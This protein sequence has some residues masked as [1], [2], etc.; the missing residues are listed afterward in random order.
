MK[1]FF[2]L[3][4]FSFALPGFS[5]NDTVIFSQLGHYY[6]SPA[7]SY[8]S[9]YTPLIDRLNRPYVYAASKEAGLVTFDISNTLNPFPAHTETVAMLNNLKPTG[10]VQDSIYLLVSLGDFEGS[11][12]SAGL[13]I[14]DISTPTSPVLLDLWDSTYFNKGTA[15]VIFQGNYA[16]LA[17]MDSGVVILDISNKTDI[18]YVSKIRPDPT[19]FA[20]AYTYHSR[21]LFLSHDTLLVA[22]DNGGLRVID[23]TNKQFPVEIGAFN[24]PAINAGAY[25][26]YNRIYRKGNYAYCT[27]DYCGLEV[28]DVSNPASMSEVA[29]INPYNCSGSGSWFSS[30]GHTNEIAPTMNPDV[31]IA[32]G[33]D[34]EVVAFDASNPSQPRRMGYYGLYHDSIVGWGVDE[35]NGLIASAL[36]HNI[37]NWPYVS[38]QG[39]LQLLNWNLILS[40]DGQ[41]IKTGNLEMYPNPAG[42]IC[43]IE[44]PAS[45]DNSFTV[46]VVDVMGRTVKTENVDPKINTRNYSLDLSG[47][48]SGMYT[49]R[50]TGEKAFYSGRIVKR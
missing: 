30:H 28:V 1:K 39:G 32:S 19:L 27:V 3:F 8:Y 12:Q 46:D 35:Y 10:V 16:Y 34:E 24:S 50:V 38:N 43:T 45:T 37:F 15:Q 13:A 5:Q 41:E 6:F 9:C 22:H 18:R 21:G 2:T 25:T 36:L 14:Y 20:H 47:M 49:I 48:S 11:G 42:D 31:L 33:G 29:W 40:T 26:F 44:L 7:S 17:A 23:V 4:L